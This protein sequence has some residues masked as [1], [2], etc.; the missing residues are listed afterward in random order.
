[1]L[2]NIFP[3]KSTPFIDWWIEFVGDPT[4]IHECRI[5]QRNQLSFHQKYLCYLEYFQERNTLLGVSFDAF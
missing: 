5:L 2:F 4:V 3:S 1:M